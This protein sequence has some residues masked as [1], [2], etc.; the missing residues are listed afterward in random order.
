MPLTSEIEDAVNIVKEAQIGRPDW[1]SSPEKY[2]VQ[3]TKY[4]VQR[5]VYRK[6]QRQVYRK[7]QR[8]VYRKVQRP[9]YGKVQRP[10]TKQKTNQHNI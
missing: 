3:S 9:V 1:M 2:S 8:P 5:P 10:V 6:V 4:K 7:V